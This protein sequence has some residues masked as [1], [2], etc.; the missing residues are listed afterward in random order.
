MPSFAP[1]RGRK[2]LLSSKTS[3]RRDLRLPQLDN[4]LGL[5]GL[6]PDITSLQSRIRVIR[7]HQRIIQSMNFRRHGAEC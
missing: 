6:V 4:Y 5:L 2:M 1:T 3:T 7:S